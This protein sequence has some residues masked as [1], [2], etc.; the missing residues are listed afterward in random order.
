MEDTPVTL[1]GVEA[2]FGPTMARLV[3]E[4]TDVSR[5][6]D[7]NRAARKA[8]DLHHLAL[9]S[10]KAKT[11]KLAD[12]IDNSRDICANHPEFLAVCTLAK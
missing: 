2:E 8:I 9:A 12:L 10:P 3:L 11:V 7:G 5:P 6:G 1:R 4:L